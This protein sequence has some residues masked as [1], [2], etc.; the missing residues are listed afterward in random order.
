MK[1]LQELNKIDPSTIVLNEDLGN[2]KSLGVGKMINAFKQEYRK[3]AER[4]G[5]LST[6]AVGKKFDRGWK[7]GPNSKIEPMGNII[8]APTFRDVWKSFD[9]SKPSKPNP[10]G[11]VVY[12]RHKPVMVLVGD[13]MQQMS[14]VVGISWDFDGIQNEEKVSAA[15]DALPLSKIHK[16]VVRDPDTWERSGSNTKRRVSGEE[17]VVVLPQSRHEKTEDGETHHYE[18]VAIT[19]R[20]LMEL[21]RR[22]VKNFGTSSLT[23][24][25][26]RADVSKPSVKKDLPKEEAVEE[27]EEELAQ[28]WEVIGKTSTGI[29]SEIVEADSEEEALKKGKPLVKKLNTNGRNFISWKAVKY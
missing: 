29:Y 3:Y 11:A 4:P 12:Y 13:D 21:I 17:R 15:L 1:L 25:L 14:D 19:V 28:Q 5:E 20:D 16:K 24:K 7:I 10:A 8:S 6:G 22:M 27:E 9:H 18:G 23:W 2:L 26:I